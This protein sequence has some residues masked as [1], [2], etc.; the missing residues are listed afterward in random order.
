LV[1]EIIKKKG[2][3]DDE[4]TSPKIRQTLQHWGYV[5]TKADYDQEKKERRQKKQKGGQIDEVC[6]T[7]YSFEYEHNKLA[8]I[9][10]KDIVREHGII[11]TF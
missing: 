6:S 10:L 5:L 3:W 8:Y 11:Q 2:K 1:T 4:I 7:N 9:R